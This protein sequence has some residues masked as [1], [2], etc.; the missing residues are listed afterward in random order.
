M[1]E[2]QKT[3]PCA[4]PTTPAVAYR[5]LAAARSIPAAAKAVGLSPRSGQMTR[6]SMRNQWP[7]RARAWDDSLEHMKQIAIRVEIEQMAQRHARQAM[8]N[9]NVLMAPAGALIERM[10]DP[11][12]A[13]E[14]DEMPIADQFH[15]RPCSS[16]ND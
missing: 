1:A 15:A 12:S 7:A 6:G 14:L 11:G 8:A 3:F 5:D 10:K 13:K 4:P 16:S 2:A 9:L